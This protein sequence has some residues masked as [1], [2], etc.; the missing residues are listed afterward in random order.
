MS[1]TGS[2]QGWAR[3]ST[4]KSFLRNK[5]HCE[6]CAAKYFLVCWEWARY[7]QFISSFYPEFW[8]SFPI[9]HLCSGVLQLLWLLTS[10]DIFQRHLFPYPWISLL[11]QIQVCRLR[12]SFI[13]INFSEKIKIYAPKIFSPQQ[14]FMK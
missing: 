14:S 12:A 13:V 5:L 2:A 7:D 3:F 11:S 1:S 8:V 6:Y 9:G 4:S 10:I